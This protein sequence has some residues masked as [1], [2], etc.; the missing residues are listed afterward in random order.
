MFQCYAFSH[1]ICQAGGEKPAT[2]ST[3]TWYIYQSDGC[4]E[5]VWPYSLKLVEVLFKMNGSSLTFD[6]F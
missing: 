5:L 1:I 4:C 2:S 6:I 3:S